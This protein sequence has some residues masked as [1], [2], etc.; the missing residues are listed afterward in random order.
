MKK[1]IALALV[2]S[3][4]L[5][6]CG[7]SQQPTSAS[8]SEQPNA[9]KPTKVLPDSATFNPEHLAKLLEGVDAWNAWRTQNASVKPDLTRADLPKHNL[10]DFDFTSA[11]LIKANLSNANLSRAIL[12]GA[13]LTGAN[14]S[15][16]RFKNAKLINT[17]LAG[18]DLSGADLTG[19]KL[20]GATYDAATIWPT[21][22]DPVA[23]GATLE[24]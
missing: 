23:A 4:V 9:P 14:L 24:Q 5:A 11:N 2:A 10:A 13:N 20:T 22:F 15:G 19:A 1:L 12:R 16:A 7:A 6:A 17:R 18:A 3:F 21:G 8:N